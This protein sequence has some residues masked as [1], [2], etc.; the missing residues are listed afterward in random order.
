VVASFWQ[1]WDVT[2]DGDLR[3]RRWVRFLLLPS[4]LLLLIAAALLLI[5][6]R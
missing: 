5:S 1:W 6:T 2:H 3:T 4:V